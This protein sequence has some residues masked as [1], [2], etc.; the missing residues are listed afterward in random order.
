MTG[1]R[2]NRAINRKKDLTNQ[3]NPIRLNNQIKPKKASHWPIPAKLVCSCLRVFWFTILIP[4][5]CTQLL[6]YITHPIT[7]RWVIRIKFCRPNHCQPLRHSD[8]HSVNPHASPLSTS[9]SPSPRLPTH[10][11]TAVMANCQ[12]PHQ[13]I[14]A[15]LGILGESLLCDLY[16]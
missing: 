14:M 13:Q 5:Y 12:P 11:K 9:H 7:N 2:N 16:Y 8:F 3:P 1:I 10:L 6:I 15:R 4:T